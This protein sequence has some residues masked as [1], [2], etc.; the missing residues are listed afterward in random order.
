MM[1]FIFNVSDT[2]GRYLGGTPCMATSRKSTIIG[3]ALRVLFFATYLPI[4][5]GSKPTFLF[6]EDWFKMLNTFLF[7]LTNGFLSTR[8]AILAP[9]FAPEA[10]R[11]ETGAMVGAVISLGI[12][13]GSILAIP[14]GQIVKLAE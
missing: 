13:T 2:L 7:G 3:V 4:A 9:S 5:F 11:Q 8:C 14:M 12:T 6:D 10:L 1:F